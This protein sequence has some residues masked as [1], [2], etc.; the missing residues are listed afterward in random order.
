MHLGCEQVN[1]PF[2]GPVLTEDK[3]GYRQDFN[4]MTL[5]Q[6]RDVDKRCKLKRIRRKVIRVVYE[7]DYKECTEIGVVSRD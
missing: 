4:L 3:H 6:Q 7:S 5:K 2:V 1:N